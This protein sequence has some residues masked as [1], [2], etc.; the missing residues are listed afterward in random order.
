MRPILF[1]L[2]LLRE[3][4][5]KFDPVNGSS[6]FYSN[7]PK[8]SASISHNLASSILP[9]ENDVLWIGTWGGGFS[10]FDKKT[11]KFKNYTHDPNNQKSLSYNEVVCIYE[12]QKGNLWIGT[13]GG[14]L[15]QFDRNDESFKS[16]NVEEKANT[17]TITIYEDEKGNFWIGTY[18]TGIH[19][20]DRDKGISIYNI[21]EKDGLAN[22]E[23]NSILEDNSGKL[24]LG[25]SN[26]LS[27][28]DP[29]TRS[30]KNYFTSDVF[31]ENR[32][33]MNSACKTSTGEMLF[34]TDVG[35]I[36]FNPDSIKDDSVRPQIV[37]SNVSLFNRPGEILTF[38]GFIS[39][40]DELELLYNENDLRF[41]YV[42][43]HFGEPEKNQYKYMLENF[44]DD[45]VE[46]GTQRNAT[47]TN[48]DAGDYIFRVTACNRDGVWNEEGA[49]LKIIILPP[50]WATCVGLYYLCNYFT[51]YYLLIP[52]RLQLKRI[53]IKHDYEMSKFEAEKM[54]EVDEMKSRF[55]ANISHEFRTPLTLNFWSCKRYY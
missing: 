53:R 54:H 5:C 44:D 30:I 23:V 22:N 4:L 11:G 55:F 52:G 6:H 50:L 35:F 51:K 7:D 17:T 37:I 46:A 10:W 41:D 45:W 40:M 19:L 18:H 32:F 12:D 43:L 21:S 27:R 1:G 20:F 16:F 26:G 34:G 3:G 49:S 25:T 15:N 8:N 2:E 28:F 48:L 42:G 13:N 33:M 36:M 31:E 38:D 39:E 24:W 47:Y 29:E 9:D 14:G